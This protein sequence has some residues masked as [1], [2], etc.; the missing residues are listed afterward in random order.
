MLSNIPLRKSQHI[1]TI[2]ALLLR[3]KLHCTFQP[4]KNTTRNTTPRYIYSLISVYCY[5]LWAWVRLPL[6]NMP[7]NQFDYLNRASKW[8]EACELWQRQNEWKNDT[9]DLINK[10][11]GNFKCQ[12]VLSAS[13][14]CASV[15]NE[16]EHTHTYIQ[17]INDDKMIFNASNIFHVPMLESQTIANIRNHWKSNK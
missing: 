17:K 14:H 8:P 6:L 5:I 9:N 3:N 16:H 4:I 2:A 7:S 1:V 11:L 15:Y 12:P 10:F 13:I